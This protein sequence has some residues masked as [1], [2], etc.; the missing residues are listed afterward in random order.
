MSLKVCRE[1][2]KPPTPNLQNVLPYSHG[3]VDDF[4]RPY[5]PSVFGSETIGS[6]ADTVPVQV[7]V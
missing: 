2:A 3:R 7:P 1:N 6:T 4:S 5:G